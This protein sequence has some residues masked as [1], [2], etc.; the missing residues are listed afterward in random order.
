MWQWHF[1]EA[2]RYP[3]RFFSRKPVLSDHLTFKPLV[4]APKLILFGR[5]RKQK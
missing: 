4:K 5:F 1:G 3:A 2:G